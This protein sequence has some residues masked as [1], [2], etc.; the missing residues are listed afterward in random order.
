MAQA[1]AVVSVARGGFTSRWVR[2]L[3]DV[4]RIPGTNI[5][6]GL[7]GIIGLMLP[8]VGDAVTGAGAAA[9]LTMAL[10]ERVPTI[11]LLRM[12]GNIGIDVLLGFFPGFGDAF[13]FVWKS[14]RRNL[15]LIQRFSRRGSAK[16]GLLDYLLVGVGL[17]LA[18]LSAVIPIVIV[19]YFG[20]AITDALTAWWESGMPFPSF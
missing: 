19:V 6:F 2:L 14:N 11:V 1:S 8:G 13:D 12:I 16:A 7:D 20:S 17:F 4:F 10:R 9:L 15:D 5:R 18:L 3:D